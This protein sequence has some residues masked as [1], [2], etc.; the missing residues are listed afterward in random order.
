MLVQQ[1][2]DRG[3]LWMV[4]EKIADQALLW[5]GMGAAVVPLATLEPAPVDGAMIAQGWARIW[6]QRMGRTVAPGALLVL[7][8]EHQAN[9]ALPPE[10]PSPV[11]RL[12]QVQDGHRSYRALLVC[13]RADWDRAGELCDRAIEELRSRGV[14]LQQ[15]AAALAMRCVL[16]YGEEV[17]DDA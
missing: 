6:M 15:F 17:L 4:A 12:L 1:V 3:G 16:Q 9:A 7:A 11:V 2:G 14:D 8:M 5:N 13:D 10:A